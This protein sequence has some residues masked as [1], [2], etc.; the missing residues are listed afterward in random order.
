MRSKSCQ[1]LHEVR[2]HRSKLELNERNSRLMLGYIAM[3]FFR[4]KKGHVVPKSAFAKS[5]IFT[6]SAISERRKSLHFIK[7]EGKQKKAMLQLYP[8][9]SQKKKGVKKRLIN[10]IMG[11]CFAKRFSTPSPPIPT[12]RSHPKFPSSYPAIISSIKTPYSPKFIP[13]QSI[14]PPTLNL[15]LPKVTWGPTPVSIKILHE[16]YIRLKL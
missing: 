9:H 3:C 7:Q 4:I 1:L 16:M 11:L 8:I 12:P 6:T 15:P 2:S 13:Q 14:I 5:L 10:F